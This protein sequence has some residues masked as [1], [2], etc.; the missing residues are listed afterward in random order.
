MIYLNDGHIRQLGIDWVLLEERIFATL[1]KLGTP[2]IVQPLKP[3]LRF[4]Q[5]RNRIIAMPAFVGGNEEICGIKWI[6]S[7]PDNV[8]RGLSR[9]H[10]TIVLND[11]TTGVPIAI[12]SGGL[13][14]QLRTAAVSAVMLRRYFALQRRSKYRIGI[15]G[16]GPIGRRHLDMV[17][18]LFGDSIAS[19]KL[20]DIKGIDSKSANVTS[21]PIRPKISSSWR[22]LYR[23]SDIVFTCTSSAERYIDEP[24]VPGALLMNVSL[25]EYLPD[26]IGEGT[27]IVVDNWQEVC[28]ENTDIELLHVQAGLQEKNTI[29]LRGAVHEEGLNGLA[30]SVPIFFNPM[31]MAAF[32]I[33]IAA[34]YR[35]KA[36]R[37][38]VGIRL[39]G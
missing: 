7:F 19:V 16:W 23:E 34:F 13:L 6:A 2:E 37:L 10:G 35:H 22:E 27:A 38:G 18:A 33:A 20:F 3:Y 4:G 21:H 17:F 26:S 5:P 12:F 31:G 24:P 25:R 36:E 32:D 30:P 8:R 29:S 11:P 15:M 39:E 9:A 14:N 1:R 28:R